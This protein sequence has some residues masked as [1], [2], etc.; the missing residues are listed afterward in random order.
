MQLNYNIT[1]LVERAKQ[2]DQLAMKL[3]YEKSAKQ[4][5]SL[6]YRIT[7]NVEDSK[8]ILQEAYLTTFQQLLKLKESKKYF[9]WLKR[10]VVNNSLKVA[11]TKIHFKEVE[12]FKQSMDEDDYSWYSDFPSG[13]LKIAIQKL[14][15][16]CREIFTLYLLEGYKHKEIAELLNIEIP[17]SKSQYQYALKLLKTDLIKYKR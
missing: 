8:D 2:K 5:F 16:G 3:L 14:P 10:I 7:N 11:K 9:G 13:K 17:T 12:D 6:S 4:M 1:E 15:N